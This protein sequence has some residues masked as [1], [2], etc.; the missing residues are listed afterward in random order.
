MSAGLILNIPQKRA[1]SCF[2]Q[3]MKASPAFAGG[4]KK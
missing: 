2:E 3:D 4:W 1:L